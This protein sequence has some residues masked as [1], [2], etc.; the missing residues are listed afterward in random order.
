MEKLLSS[1]SS[2]LYGSLFRE[3]GR[4]PTLWEKSQR[5]NRVVRNGIVHGEV[6]ESKQTWQRS[7]QNV[8]HR[9]FDNLKLKIIRI[10]ILILCSKS[11]GV[12]QMVCSVLQN[13]VQTWK[14][15]SLGLLLAFQAHFT[16]LVLLIPRK[17][18]TSSC[19][20]AVL[21]AASVLAEVLQTWAHYGC[22][23]LCASCKG[24]PSISSSLVY[25]FSAA[26]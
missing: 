15:F 5:G 14:H 22:K 17:M 23:I 10:F 20:W 2:M 19:K 7:L 8:L 13:Y 26:L 12:L 9:N 21:S 11:T 24:S 25:G 18:N 4:D 1:K 3:L 6:S 16:R